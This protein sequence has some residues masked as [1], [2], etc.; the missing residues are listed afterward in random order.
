MAKFPEDRVYRRKRPSLWRTFG[1]ILL[2]GLMLVAAWYFGEWTDSRQPVSV[3]GQ[4]IFIADGDSFSVGSQKLRL[5]GIDAPEYRQDCKDAAGQLWPCGRTA[6]AALEKLLTEPE[7]ACEAEAHDR[8]ARSLATC[9]TTN[10]PDIAAV[11]VRD[12]MAVSD[13]FNGMRSYGDEE[14][15]ARTAKRGIWQGEFEHPADYRASKTAPSE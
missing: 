1:K 10:T 11:Q 13:E 8:Y 7:L 9:R 14:D 15:A 4:K 2:L 6:R 12:G 3:Q 5:A